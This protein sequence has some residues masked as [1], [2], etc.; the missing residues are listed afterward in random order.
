MITTAMVTQTDE[1]HSGGSYLS[2]NDLHV[3]FG[4]GEAKKIISVEIR[5]PSGKIETLGDLAA[6]QYYSILEGQSLVSAERIRFAP[7]KR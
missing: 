3:H 6:D 1:I 2:Q 5:W 4:L 7:H